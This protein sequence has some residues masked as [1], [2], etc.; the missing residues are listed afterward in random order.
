MLRRDALLICGVST[1]LAVEGIV[2][3][4]VNRGFEMFVVEDCCASF[5][6]EWHEFSIRN[7]MP[8]LA[9]VT[10]SD[11]VLAALAAARMSAPLAGRTVVVTGASSGIGRALA[12]DLV[13]A[14]ARV[15]AAARSTD[16]LQ[17]LAAEL[18]G[19]LVPVAADVADPAAVERLAAAA[20]AVDV[21]VNN[22]GLGHVEPFLASDLGALAADARHQS[23]R[24]AA[25][26]AR[27]PARHARRRPRPDRQRRLDERDGLAVPDALRRLQGGAAGGQHR[28]RPR[29]CRPRRA[30]RV[31][32][33][34]P[35]RGHRLRRAF[36]SRSICRR[37]R[38]AWT[39]LGI[40]WQTAGSA[41]E[42]S[43]R[44]IRAG[45]RA[46]AAGADVAGPQ[47][48]RSAPR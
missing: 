22:A 3:A 11:A 15:I 48:R 21:V 29:A 33:D 44:T 5:P 20:G 31:R 42:T 2:R 36:R 14:G 19:A 32:R 10:S 45:D 24:R 7:I 37:R 46:R 38:R 16:K 25:G 23:D 13:D 43:A 12:R 6:D 28:A 47:A 8:L 40:D 35:D 17:A 1:N 39:E 18:G 27:L 34:R 4:S 26:H 9:T 30:R 41:P